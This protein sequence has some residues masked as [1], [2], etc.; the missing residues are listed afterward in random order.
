MAEARPVDIVPAADTLRYLSRSA[1]SLLSPR[2]VDYEQL[3]FTHKAA[4]FRF[5]PLGVIAVITPWNFPFGIPFVEI[6]ACLVAGNTVVLKPASV[7][8][9]TGI[10]V[11]DLCRR[12]GLPPGVVNV[13]P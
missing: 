1:E 5:E 4:S 10:L 9:L 13:V 6:A 7:T 12:A 11:G 2:G 3:L 8:A